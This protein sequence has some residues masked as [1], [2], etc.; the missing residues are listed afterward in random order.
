MCYMC[1]CMSYT[2]VCVSHTC[3]CVCVCVPVEKLS[4]VVVAIVIE[5]RG[6]Q[7]PNEASKGGNARRSEAVAMTRLKTTTQGEEKQQQ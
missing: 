2:C 1:V 3:V 7:S 4:R 6:E 5:D